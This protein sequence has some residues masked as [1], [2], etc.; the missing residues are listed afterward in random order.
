MDLLTTAAKVSVAVHT[1]PYGGLEVADLAEVLQM[2]VRHHR[3]CGW[4][5]VRHALV[6]VCSAD[7]GRWEDADA[8]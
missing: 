8:V 1:L 7:E 3:P 2:L 6:G 5:E 4:C